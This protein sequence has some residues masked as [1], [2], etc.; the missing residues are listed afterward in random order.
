MNQLLI[1]LLIACLASCSGYKMVKRG[2]PFEDESISSVAIPMFIN[3]SSYPGM[4]GPFTRE[5]TS[6]LSSFPKLSISTSSSSNS[7]AILI[8]IIEGPKRHAHA[9]QT[10]ATK[11]TVGELEESIGDRS[12]FYLPTASTFTVNL[13]ILLIK[14]P[15][16]ADRK[17]LTSEVG[18]KLHG[19]PKLIFQRTM[20]YNPSFNRES[21]DTI[22]ADSGGI[23][24]YP[25]T[26]RY[27]DQTVERIAKQSAI[28]LQELVLNV[29]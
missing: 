13:R 24:N 7:D 5:I 9:F 22:N 18:K 19:H 27:F 11:Y 15:T 26:R 12:Q 1:I 25:K 10:T 16:T 14:N 17:L 29:F 28:D 23:V 3:K 4:S 2:N 6:L 21:K 20:T 8:G